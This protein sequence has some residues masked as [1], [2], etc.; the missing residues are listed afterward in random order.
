MSEVNCIISIR[1]SGPTRRIILF[2]RKLRIK[3]NSFPMNNR[4]LTEF[5]ILKNFLEQL[6]KHHISIF[7][8]I[9]RKCCFH[10]WRK[11]H[12]WHHREVPRQWMDSIW[13]SESWTLRTWIY[14]KC[15]PDYDRW[16]PIFFVSEDL[17]IELITIIRR[18]IPT[19][20]WNFN[21]GDNK[22]IQ[23]TLPKNQ[24][25]LGIGLYLVDANFCKRQ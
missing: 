7:C 20:V 17:Q 19:E 8:R 10:Y 14:H 15:W 5:I 3:L 24:Y 25:Y 11:A 23:P 18:D 13:K 2:H 6:F 9:Y 12:F 1:I 4:L 21:N 22:L 16:W